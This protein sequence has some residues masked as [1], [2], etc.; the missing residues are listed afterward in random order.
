MLWDNT[1]TCRTET[2]QKS[3]CL[4]N[5]GALAPVC[6]GGRRVSR[7]NGFSSD[8]NKLLKQFCYP[9]MS[10]HRA[11]A[12]V[13][14]RT[15]ARKWTFFLLLSSAV[16][17]PLLFS[18]AAAPA[19]TDYATIDAI[20]S[21]HCLDCHA[22]KDPEGQLILET[23]ENLMK[24]GEKGP[25]IV[26]HKSAESLLVQMIEGRFEKGGKTKIMPPGKRAK[27]TP[28]QIASI[29]G[30]I[31]AGAPAPAPGTIRK[32]LNV[33]RIEPKRPARNPV[34]SLA[35]WS[36]G[37]VLAVARYCE[38]ELRSVTNLAVIRTL[39][40][41]AGNVNALVF[42]PDGARLFAAGGQPGFAGEVREWNISEGQPGR[43][44]EGHSDSIYALAISPDGETL[45]TGSYDQKIKLWDLASGKEIRTLSGH[46]GCIYGLAFRPDGKIL[47]SASADR[48]VKLWD[49][50]TG[51]R[52][53][54]LSQSAK[55]L[56][57]VAF[58]ANG[59]RLVAGGAD[60]RI[61][62]W[63]ISPTAAETTNPILHSKFAHEGAILKLIFSPDG[64]RILSSG[65][66]RT[67]KFWQAE[68]MTQ[69]GML[70]KQPDWASALAFV[71]GNRIAIGRL[72]GTIGLYDLTNGERTASA[73]QVRP[74]PRAANLPDNARAKTGG[75]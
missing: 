54:T 74:E 56:F 5:T 31:D 10:L 27:L 9:V 50:N 6:D 71:A 40:G 26:P 41:H 28:E 73:G 39:P 2:G 46:N 43:A 69:L 18:A 44:F 22:S 37:E 1:A 62:V 24:G 49:V 47:A 12:P 57:T 20:F 51:D 11:K 60:N 8:S 70:E 25:A 23:F 3:S 7:F 42:S 67:V 63:Q 36:A 48:T 68:D 21:S 29:K 15:S 45:A 13:L 65:E 52:R 16:L 75:Q 17:G 34:N 58:S 35:A 4:I 32:G 72:D 61:R 66:D 19:A 14:I 38:V 55:E 33:P 64:K 30:W 59:E 53:D